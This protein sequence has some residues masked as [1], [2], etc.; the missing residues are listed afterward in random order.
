MIGPSRRG[1]VDPEIL[2]RMIWV[3][4]I[5][6]MIFAL[7]GLGLFF[8]VYHVTESLVAGAAVGFG[9]HFVTLAFAG[10]ISRF[11]TDAVS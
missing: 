11:I 4:T 6:A 8:A 10:R 5:L 7:P 2:T 1:R 3:S 9:S